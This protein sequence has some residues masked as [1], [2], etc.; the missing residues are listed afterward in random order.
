LG[1]VEFGDDVLP[2]HLG[3]SLLWGSGGG[4]LLVCSLPN[5]LLVFMVILVI[6]IVACV[7][8]IDCIIVVVVAC[9]LIAPVI[10]I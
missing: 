10:V 5:V 4:L 9:V 8:V 6:V 1:G 3:A 7:L 2:C